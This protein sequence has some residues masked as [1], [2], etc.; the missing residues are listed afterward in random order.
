MVYRSDRRP[1][2]SAGT[3]GGKTKTLNA[4][5]EWL[6]SHQQSPF[7]QRGKVWVDKQIPYNQG[8]T[9][10]PDGS[11]ATTTPATEPTVLDS[12]AWRGGFP[13]QV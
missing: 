13:Q 3:D 5:S 1:I 11:R 9:A 6:A 2:W 10:N 12:S 4:A 8:L 7:V